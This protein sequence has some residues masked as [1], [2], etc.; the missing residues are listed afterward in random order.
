MKAANALLKGL[1]VA[2]KNV[3]DVGAGTG[4]LSFLLLEMGA[5]RVTCGDIS[6]YMMSQCRKK[7]ERKGYGEGRIDFRNLDA[8]SLPFED[9]SFDM[10][11]TGKTLGLLPHQERAIQEM[12]RVVRPG[13]IVSV[14]AHGPED[15]WEAIDACFRAVTKRYVLGYRLEFWPRSEE[16]V[17]DMM[18]HAGLSDIRTSRET[19]QTHFATGG[20]AFDFFTA[21]SSAWWYA[22]FPEE[23]R[24]DENRKVRAYFDTNG[25]DCI[26]DDFVLAY[27]TKTG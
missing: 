27:G 8:E 6:D 2:G 18:I 21:I 19:L 15:Y 10:V 5:A 4:A 25:E 13:G 9:N 7:A 1:D 20:D 17:R 22:K 11:V 23:K 26:T 24:R 16:Q 12:A 3:L 14:G